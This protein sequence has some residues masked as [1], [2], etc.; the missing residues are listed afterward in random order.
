MIVTPRSIFRSDGK[1]LTE[2]SATLSTGYKR[3]TS[4]VFT[5][6][7]KL[8]QPPSSNSRLS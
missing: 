6:K 1:N 4:I 2:I 5:A 7:M 3:A 8:R